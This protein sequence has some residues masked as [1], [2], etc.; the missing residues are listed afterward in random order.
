M[1]SHLMFNAVKSFIMNVAIFTG[2]A[3]R[4]LR[5]TQCTIS[6]HVHKFEK[7]GVG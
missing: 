7:E 1:L 4:L 6:L 3:F 2:K 5:E